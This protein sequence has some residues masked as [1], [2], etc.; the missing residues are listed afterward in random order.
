[1][2]VENPESKRLAEVAVDALEDLKGISIRHIEVTGLTDITDFMVIAT[3]RSS[4]HVKALADEVVK[5]VRESGREVLGVE[6]RSHSEWVLVDAGDVL[7]H[8]MVASVRALYKLEDLWDFE[9]TVVSQTEA[10]PAIHT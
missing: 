3:G 9:A 5:K 10:A 7:I 4:T 1:M 6:G 2:K 8:V